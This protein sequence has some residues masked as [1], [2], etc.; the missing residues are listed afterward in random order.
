MQSKLSTLMEDK[1]ILNLL[2]RGEYPKA[3]KVEL[4]LSNTM[5]IYNAVRRFKQEEKNR[6]QNIAKIHPCT[7]NNSSVILNTNDRQLRFA[8]FGKDKKLR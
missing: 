8:S 4:K 6:L 3:I 5:R 7:L 1:K 2:L